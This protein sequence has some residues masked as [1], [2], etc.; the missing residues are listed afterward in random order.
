LWVAK[1]TDLVLD[2]RY[3]RS[4][5]RYAGLLIPSQAPGS[6]QGFSYAWADATVARGLS[7]WYRVVAVGPDGGEEPL[8]VVRADYPYAWL[9]LPMVARP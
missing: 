9:W 1:G 4:R 3:T 8:Q 2:R 5:R 6:P 7:Y